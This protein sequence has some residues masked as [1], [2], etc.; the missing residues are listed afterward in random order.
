MKRLTSFLLVFALLLSMMPTAFAA[1]GAED[2][3]SAPDQIDSTTVWRYLDD[4]TDPAGT[5]GSESYNRTSWTAV[6]FDDSAW[7]TA[8]GSFGAKNDGTSDGADHKLD[9][10]NGSSN[11]PTYY[12]RTKVNVSD[13]NAVTKITGTIA[14][15]DAVIVYINGEKAFSYN[16]TG[17]DTNSSYCTNKSANKQTE[18]FEITDSAVLNNLVSGTN[19]IAVELHNQAADS[20]DIWFP[21]PDMPFST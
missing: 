21:M 14:F 18:S 11:Y 2:G 19:V 16:D 13:A 17:A 20:S 8:S 7:K 4:N 10:C 6:G 9:G 12:F 1:G 5:P 15:D 3:T